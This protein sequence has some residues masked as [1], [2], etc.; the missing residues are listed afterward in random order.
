MT[1][2]LRLSTGGRSL[3]PRRGG[4]TQAD[5]MAAD[6]NQ[7]RFALRVLSLQQRRRDID[8]AVGSD[9]LDLEVQTDQTEDEA[10]DVLH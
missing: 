1:T 10:L 6:Y 7:I 8:A 3:R 4:S 5:R 9:G 2:S